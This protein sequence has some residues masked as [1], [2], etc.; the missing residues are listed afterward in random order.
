M[1]TAT[2]RYTLLF[3]A[4]SVA[5]CG[6]QNAVNPQAVLAG[7]RTLAHLNYT[8]AY[9]A[10]GDLQVAIAKLDANP[11]ASTLEVAREA[12]RAARVP[13]ARSEALRFGNRFVDEWQTRVNA[14]PV[15]EGFIDY[16]ARG[17]SASPGNRLARLNLIAS[18]R[19]TIAGSTLN[20]E[21]MRRML[22][23]QAQAL[24]STASNVATGYHAIE[25]MLW[26]QDLNGTGPGAGQRPWTDFAHDAATCTDGPSPAPLRHCNRRRDFL[27]ELVALLRL[28]LRDMAGQWGPQTGSQGDRLV[29]GDPNTGLRRMLH[30]LVTMSGRELAGQRMQRALLTHAQEFEQDAFSDDTHNSLFFNAQG[31]ENF[32]YGRAGARDM[33]VSLADLALRSDADLALQ[34]DLAF[35]RTRAAMQSIVSAGERGQS[36]DMLIAAGNREGAALVREAIA[37]LQAQ[38]LLLKTLGEVLELGELDPK[39]AS[40]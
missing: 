25:F 39:S 30:G 15:D 4:L 3:A 28:D 37:T 8:K 20:T 10:A 9:Q 1:R 24:S 34:L 22:L 27:R 2:I 29:E 21:P 33:P 7:Y 5:G 31:I 23:Q 36:F 18:E 16:V 12:W 14:W 40:R 6:G 38:A 26:G 13:Y 32:Y 35:A 19:V 11:S 17:Y